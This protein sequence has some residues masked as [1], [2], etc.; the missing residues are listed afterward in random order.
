MNGVDTP[1]LF[2]TI[3]AV[4]G[5]RDLARF[6]FRATNRWLEGTHSETTFEA[7]TGA[8]GRHEQVGKSV[9]EGDHPPV[10]C[11]K[12]AAPTPVEYLLHAIASCIMAGIGNIAAARGVRLTR[13]EI[14][15]QGDIDLQGL[16]GISDAVRNGY[17]R[18]RLDVSLEGDASPEVLRDIVE[19]SKARSAVFDV[20][21]NGV[22]VDVRVAA[23]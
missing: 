5:Q 14:S 18:I 6:Q 11:G 20:L 17:E 21:T 16:L 23:R 3:D 9:V 13:A 15:A 2:A 10:L 19:R 12:G 7:F 8:G 22:P 1:A 4:K